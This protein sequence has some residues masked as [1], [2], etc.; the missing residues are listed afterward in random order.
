MT[1]P[2]GTTVPDGEEIPD[3][4]QPAEEAIEKED[5]KF[6]GA[7]RRVDDVVILVDWLPREDGEMTV[8][9]CGVTMVLRE[10]TVVLCGVTLVLGEVMRVV[11]E[12]VM[13]LGDLTMVLG[14]VMMVLGEV[15]TVL[16]DVTIVDLVVHEETSE[17]GGLI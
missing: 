15:A 1:S 8:V 3:K 5:G 10:V 7:T 13:A 17:K 14:E 11:G 16:G 9:L 2:L 6:D 4:E 12:V